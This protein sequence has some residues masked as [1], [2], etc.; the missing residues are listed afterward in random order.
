MSRPDHSALELRPDLG[1]IAQ[2]IR[3]KARVLDLGCG[4]GALLAW[5]EKEKG[6]LA[7]GAEINQ[8]QVLACVQ[9]GV[10][11][12]QA[13]IDT[14]LSLFSGNRFDV[15]I[16]SQALQATHRTEAVLREISALGQEV[17]VSIPNFGHWSHLVSLL[18][19]RMPVNRRLP[20]EWY[21]TPNLHLATV[22]DFETLLGRLRLTILERQ[23]LVE[24]DSGDLKSI[25]SLPAL[26]ATLALYRFQKQ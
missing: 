18:M 19:G 14:S 26:R 11:V 9:R 1:R 25:A 23:Y 6:C 15:V 3:P 7:Y 8:D 17:I 16:L 22:S 12:I 2:W 4:D 13:D 5:L 21:N 24:S 20:Y 10:N